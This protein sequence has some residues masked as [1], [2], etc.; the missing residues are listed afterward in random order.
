MTKLIT[1]TAF[2]LSLALPLLAFAQD[3][4][5]EGDAAEAPA[6]GPILATEYDLD[7]VVATV[8]GAEITLGN[9][10]ALRDR[11]PQ[12]YR[13]LPAEILLPGLIDQLIDQ[14]LLAQAAEADGARDLR[15]VRVQLENE[16]RGILSNEEIARVLDAAVTEE[17]IAAAYEELTAGMTRTTEY[18]ASHILLETEEDALDVIAEIEGGAD[19]AETAV[20]RSTGPSGPSGGELGWFGPGQMVPEF[21]AAVQ[22]LEVG[23]VS[24]PVQTQF[25]WHVIIVNE[26]RLSPLPPREQVEPEIA[27]QLNQEAL[28]ARIDELRAS[29]EVVRPDVVIP[30]EAL[31]T[32]D[33]ADE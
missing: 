18:N 1:S 31:T 22:A 23:T 13:S 11:L 19:F 26:T 33:L 29:A 3:T 30:G 6:E 5:A 8:D 21:D 14:Q 24:Q 12:N 27:Q 25:G 15:R 20:A 2:A 17:K 28:Q 10:I 16:T 9:V 32:L 7:T 4:A